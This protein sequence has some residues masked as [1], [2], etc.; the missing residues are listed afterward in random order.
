ME[1]FTNRGITRTV[2][3][4]VTL[5]F[6]SLAIWHVSSAQGVSPRSLS[7]VGVSPH[8]QCQNGSPA[9]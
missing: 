9:Q 1:L 7:R 6:A 4:L 8:G 5:M 3:L 2:F